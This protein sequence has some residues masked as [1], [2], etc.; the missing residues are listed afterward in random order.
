MGTTRTLKAVGAAFG[1]GNAAL[2]NVIAV[3][4]GLAALIEHSGGG[5]TEVAVVHFAVIRFDAHMLRIKCAQ[6]H[7]RADLQGFADRNALPIFVGYL[8]VRHL[9]LRPILAHLRFPLAEVRRGAAAVSGEVFV[10]L[11]GANIKLFRVF[12]HHAL[13][14]EHRRDAAN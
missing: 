1:R 6:M 9:H 5:I 10:C 3:P 2:V 7:A 12:L 11:R 4:V 8:D 13:R 14:V